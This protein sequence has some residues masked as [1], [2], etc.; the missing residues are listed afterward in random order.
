VRVR[1]KIGGAW[2]GLDWEESKGHFPYIIFDFSFAIERKVL[3]GAKS[4][5]LKSKQLWA[6]DSCLSS[7][8][9]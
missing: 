4:L 8:D 3:D 5:E 9:Q 1:Q 7:N 6:Y 2:G